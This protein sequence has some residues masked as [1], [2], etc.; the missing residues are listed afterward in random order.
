MWEIK[1]FNTRVV[2]FLN[3]TDFSDIETQFHPRLKVQQGFSKTQFSK[4]FYEWESSWF[5]PTN[6]P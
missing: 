5:I 1:T 3:C 6:A 2:V 4:D